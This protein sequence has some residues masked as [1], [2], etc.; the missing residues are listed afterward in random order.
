M[1][2]NQV[3]AIVVEAKKLVMAAYDVVF[4]SSRLYMI[5][6]REVVYDHV[7]NMRTCEFYTHLDYSCTDIHRNLWNWD[8]GV[9]RSGQEWCPMPPVCGYEPHSAES[10]YK[11]RRAYDYYLQAKRMCDTIPQ[12]YTTWPKN[13]WHT[14]EVIRMLT[15]E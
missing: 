13:V 3:D 6:E 9:E 15:G 4:S 8:T 12:R 7:R 2:R 14:P 1:E 10:A 5:S 11:L